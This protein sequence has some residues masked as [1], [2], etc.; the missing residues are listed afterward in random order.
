MYPH[1]PIDNYLLD[2]YQMSCAVPNNGEKI[3][4]AVRPFGC[5]LHF[6]GGNRL[7]QAN[8]V[9]SDG[10]KCYLKTGEDRTMSRSCGERGG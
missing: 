2:I 3:E 6:E 10:E 9:I 7:L 8:N 1:I 4:N 5:V